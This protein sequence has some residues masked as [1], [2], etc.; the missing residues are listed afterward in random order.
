MLLVNGSA[1]LYKASD[2]TRPCL[3]YSWVTPAIVLCMI[4][5]QAT[6]DQV[7][8]LAGMSTLWTRRTECGGLQAEQLRPLRHKPLWNAQRSL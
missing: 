4:L 6:C 8:C 2:D 3:C 5:I 7:A 1:Q